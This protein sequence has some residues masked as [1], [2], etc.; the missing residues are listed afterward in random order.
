MLI[1]PD[2]AFL[3]DPWLHPSHPRTQALIADVLRRLGWVVDYPLV[4]D[5]VEQARAAWRSA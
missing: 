3:F 4:L 2:A 5:V 1:C